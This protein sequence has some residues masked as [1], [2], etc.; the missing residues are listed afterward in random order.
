MER[1]L[2]LAALGATSGEVPVGAVLVDNKSGEIISEAHNAPIETHDPTA[3]AEIQALRIAG[4][5]RQNY[6]LLNT[7]LYVTLEPCIMCAGAISFARVDRLV[8]GASDPKGGGIINGP[9]FFEQPT[10]HW[11]PKVDHGILEDQ[12]GEILRSFFRA[13]RQT[14]PKPLAK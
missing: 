14:K 8:F 3:H 7:T 12:C 2:E 4:Q 10:C 5:K 9:R 13:R 6:R 1:A 11:R